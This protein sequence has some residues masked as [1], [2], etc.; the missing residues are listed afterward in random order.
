MPNDDPMK[1]WQEQ[2]VEGTA[3]SMD[4]IRRR[5]GRFEYRIRSR[6]KR[7]YLGA[8]IVAIMFT[9]YL[10]HFSDWAIRVGSLLVLAGTA[11]VVAQLY[12]RSSPLAL[13]GELGLTGSV[14]FY[15]RELVRQRDLLR[16]VW[17]WYLAPLVPGLLVI[18]KGKIVT[19][20]INV[21]VFG[22]VWW[23]NQ[24][25][26]DRLTRQIEELDQL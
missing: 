1:I 19:L 6:N 17:S 7:E 11:Y 12:R 8:A 3:I 26:A 4:E 21:L 25:A 2:P 20:A 9:F 15:R 13:P 24:R 18:S 5:A 14:E 23:I 22:G 16:S 10:F